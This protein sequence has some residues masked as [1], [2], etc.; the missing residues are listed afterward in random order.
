MARAARRSRHVLIVLTA[1]AATIAL[2]RLARAAGGAYQVDTSD[3][4]AG[5]CKV[6][7]WVSSAA[8]RDVIAAVNPA[9]AFAMLRPVE[10]GMQ[11][12]RTRT[13]DEWSSGMTPKIKANLVPSGIGTFGIAVSTTAGFDPNSRE[14][15]S[16]AFT[17]PL[18]MR[19][20]EDVRINLNAGWLLDRTVERHYFTYGA[21]IDW[22]THDNLYTFTA[23]V[24]GQS[25]AAE[26][27]SV[28][29]PRF[30][31]G[32]RWRPIDEF[33]ID[34]IYGHNIAGE[35]ANWITIDTVIRFSPPR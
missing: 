1:V 19:L 2:P 23:E 29:R 27:S 6:E 15:T 30:Q 9:C 17:A 13:D 16:L 22:R 31:A 21:S 11:M 7:S 3:V 28:I 18:T 14:N 8:N 35:N 12:T 10:F 24:F 20:S 33:S 32:V 5:A 25:G 4:T 26:E 34:V